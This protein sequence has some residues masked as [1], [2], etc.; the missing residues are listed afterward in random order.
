M[1]LNS[2]IY[3]VIFGFHPLIT[4]YKYISKIYL[5]TLCN[6]HCSCNYEKIFLQTIRKISATAYSE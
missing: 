3:A 6:S 5:V 1:V 4:R 2:E